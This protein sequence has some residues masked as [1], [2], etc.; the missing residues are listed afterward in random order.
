[1][2]M[3]S[4]EGSRYVVITGMIGAAGGGYWMELAY[5]RFM[6]PTGTMLDLAALLVSGALAVTIAWCV[7]CAGGRLALVA[8]LVVAGAAAVVGPALVF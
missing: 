5:E 1:M 7:W 2:S 4:I 3:S 6:A 8:Y